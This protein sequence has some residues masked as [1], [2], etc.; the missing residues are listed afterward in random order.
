MKEKLFDDLF[1]LI[2]IGYMKSPRYNDRTLISVKYRCEFEVFHN[3]SWQG[4]WRITLNT[5]PSYYKGSKGWVRRPY[6]HLRMKF[7]GKTLEETA[8]KAVKSLSEIQEQF[9]EI[10]RLP[11]LSEVRRER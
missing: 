5:V 8:A 4:V 2:Q 3:N 9:G 11:V 7:H 6:D 10:E 1:R